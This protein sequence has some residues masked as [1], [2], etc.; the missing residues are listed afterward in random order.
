LATQAK[1]DYYEILG[2][3]RAA[4]TEEIEH[5]HGKLVSEIRQAGGETAID[6]LLEANRARAVLVNPVERKQY[7]KFGYAGNNNI[8]KLSG[9][10]DPA[11]LPA[12][13][14][15][16]DARF[17]PEGDH[18]GEIGKAII[19]DVIAGILDIL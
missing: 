1:R 3:T 17:A 10:F 13:C 4:S 7:D 2:V 9:A 15:D 16:F 6:R 11:K 5:A 12:P 18:R 8:P 19:S 14:T